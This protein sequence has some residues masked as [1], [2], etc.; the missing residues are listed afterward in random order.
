MITLS[1]NPIQID[2]TVN[3]GSFVG[4][5]RAENGT[6]DDNFKFS[7][8]EFQLV[9]QTNNAGTYEI[10]ASG[11]ITTT[12]ELVADKSD[13]LEIKVIDSDGITE[14]A[15]VTLT[16]NT[17]SLQ[18]RSFY[19]SSVAYDSFTL[20]QDQQTSVLKYHTGVGA[21]PVVGDFVY[22][23]SVNALTPA[24]LYTAFNSDGQWHTMSKN[25]QNSSIFSFRTNNTGEVTDISTQ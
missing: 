11:G 3:I 4:S 25:P 9:S 6:A 21:T 17:S 5:A 8:M 19:I 22:T 13:S 7:D 23:Y 18:Y 1:I 16:I 12:T 24:G 2:H 15:S 20:A 10:S 14:S